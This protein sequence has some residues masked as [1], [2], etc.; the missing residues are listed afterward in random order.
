M[1]TLSSALSLVLTLFLLGC[2]NTTA[3]MKRTKIDYANAGLGPD[4]LLKL[5]EQADA[6]KGK[7]TKKDLEALGVNFKAKNLSISTGPDAFMM[8]YGTNFFQGQAVNLT[9]EVRSEINQH[10]LIQI[11]YTAVTNISDRI[12]LNKKVTT[13][14]GP[15]IM[16]SVMLK[17]D[18]VVEATKRFVDH[19]GKHVD[20]RLFGGIIDLFGE[21]GSAVGAVAKPRRRPIRPVKGGRSKRRSR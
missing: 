2:G 5:F 14:K 6:N 17:G 18:V 9:P 21:A 7:L 19:D 15:E 16:I 1:K 11:P 20:R 4:H 12:Y 8:A 10:T 3:L 13:I